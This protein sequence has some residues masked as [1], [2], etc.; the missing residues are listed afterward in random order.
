MY[1]K[2]LKNGNINNIIRNLFGNFER[3]KLKTN[4]DFINNR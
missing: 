1:V 2:T 3:N 4:Y